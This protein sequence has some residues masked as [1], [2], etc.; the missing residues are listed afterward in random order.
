MMMVTFV[1]RE[2]RLRY[3]FL[4]TG[5]LRGGAALTEGVEHGVPPAQ[6][7]SLHTIVFSYFTMRVINERTGTRVSGK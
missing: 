2:I 6:S 5:V 1:T 7:A 3:G 4:K